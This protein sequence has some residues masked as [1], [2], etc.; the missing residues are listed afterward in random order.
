MRE[1]TIG[2]RTITDDGPPYVIAE[3]GSNHGGDV[4][5]CMEMIETAKE[6]GC[7]A[8]KLQKRD[9]R[10][11][12]TK[13]FY[14][15]SYDS[16]GSYGAT[17]GEHR[18][19]LEFDVND[20]VLIMDRARELEIDC[21]ATPFDERSA[22][23]LYCLS[24][25]V[26]KVASAFVTDFPLL[27]FLA[28]LKKP[29]VISTAGAATEDCIRTYQFLKN[30]GFN[31]FAFLHCVAKY[32]GCQLEEL[33]LSAIEWMREIFPDIIIGYSSHY[34][35]PW[36]GDWADNHGARII[37]KHFTLNRGWKG[38]D[39]GFSL[40]PDGMRLMV[41]RLRE[42]RRAM[43]DG[44]KKVMAD[45]VAPLQKMARSVWVAEPVAAGQVLTEDRLCLKSPALSAP[46]AEWENIVGR[47][48]VCD[49]STADSLEGK[50]E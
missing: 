9:N 23:F 6:C 12:Y 27:L 13:A 44:V 16:P 46:A 31:D 43:G 19:A 21:F 50:Y 2:K 18:E 26:F 35:K 15:R 49:L 24:V 30:F 42:K 1:L 29:L 32:G 38:T 33:N 3:I 45:E 48:A 7:D 37:E 20:W 17:Y 14:N 8:V 4:G 22:W 40:E 5:R 36:D 41:D 47:V 39:Q 28:N 34:E 25:P 10:T 11:L